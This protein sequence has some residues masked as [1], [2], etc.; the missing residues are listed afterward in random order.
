MTVSIYRPRDPGFAEPGSPE[1]NSMIT[2]SKA[3]AICGVS[4]WS[5]PYETWLVMKGRV[6]GEPVKDIFDTGKAMELALA[7]LWKLRNPT[8]RLSPRHVQYRRDDLGFIAAVTPDRVGSRG[9]ARRLVEMKITRD[10]EE[11]GDVD[12]EGDIPADYAT[13]LIFQMGVSG[14]RGPAD[15]L[16]MGPFFTEKLYTVVWDESVWRWIVA[17]CKRFWASL[18]ADEPPELDDSVATYRAVRQLHPEIAKGK[19]VEIP[20]ALAQDYGR[21]CV[22]SRT[23]EA[24]L[25]GI[26]SKILSVAGDAQFVTNGGDTIAARQPHFRGGVS[27][28]PKVDP[29]LLATG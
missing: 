15:L 7:E 11:W 14:Q 29:V 10:W 4:R 28:V 6:E 22:E 17:N 1:H 16:A 25:R 12:Q 8:W 26:K 23:A 3:A 9:R 5:S 13:Q 20:D 24:A 21:A 19:A 2:A 18:A 27:L